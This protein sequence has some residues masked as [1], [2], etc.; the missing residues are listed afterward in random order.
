MDCKGCIAVV[1]NIERFGTRRFIYLCGELV[2]LR[3]SEQLW[4]N[5]SWRCYSNLSYNEKLESLLFTF[6]KVGVLYFPHYI[7]IL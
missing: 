4:S 1:Y 6:T 3:P 7:D 2:S 5:Q